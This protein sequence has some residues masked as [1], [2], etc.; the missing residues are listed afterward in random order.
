MAKIGL[1]TGSLGTRASSSQSPF[2]V[3]LCAFKINDGVTSKTVKRIETAIIYS[4]NCSYG[5]IRHKTTDRYSEW[6][7]IEPAKMRKHVDRF[8]RKNHI[9]HMRNYF[10]S[11]RDIYV[12]YTWENTM[13][14]KGT[15]RAP[16]RANDLSSPPVDPVCF[17][18]GGC[19]DCDCDC[20]LWE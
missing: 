16:Y 9:S 3:L 7:Y 17:T 14:L 13:Y 11:E 8:L 18:P 20:D 10:C 4:L 1:T 19:V 15:S 5:H 12:L 6:F 2:Y